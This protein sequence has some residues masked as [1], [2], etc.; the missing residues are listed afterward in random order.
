MAVLSQTVEIHWEGIV[1]FPHD[2]VSERIGRQQDVA[3][4]LPWYAVH[5]QSKFERVASTLLHDKGYQEFLPLYRAKRRWSDRMKEM[6]L[7]LFPG[8]LFCRIDVGQGVLPILT[9]PG[10]VRIV[11][12]GKTPVAVEEREIESIQA[13]LRSGLAALPWPGLAAGSRIL[14]E[15]GPL[16]G[17]EGTVIDLNKKARLIV[18]VSL[19]QRSLAV[20]VE[21]EWIRPIGARSQSCDTTP[22][23]L[24][25]Q[26]S[27]GVA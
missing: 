20:E 1:E 12:A 17:V 21:R 26:N 19:L 18:S 9:T 3:R 25:Q 24:R 15:H 6:E 14:V 13:V 27:D 22:S 23:G 5:V 16:T 8:Y 11:S 4:N 7:P 10:V 2:T